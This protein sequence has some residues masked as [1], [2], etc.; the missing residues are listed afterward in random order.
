VAAKHQSFLDVLILVKA[1]PQPK[2]VMKRSLVW[3]PVLGFYALRMGNSPVTR[4]RGKASVDEM[5]TEIDKRKDLSGQLVI[6]PQGTRIPPGTDAPYKIGAH[7][8]YETYHLP[9]MPVAVNTG[10]FWPRVGVRR[11]RGIAV[12]KF[13]NAIPEGLNAPEFLETLRTS[14]EPA[15]DILS[16]EATAQHGR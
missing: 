16:D 7:R 13:L 8:V 6:Y 3:V 4:G 11:H 9:C 15:S 1:L 12:I 5:M 2:F 14:I 10:H